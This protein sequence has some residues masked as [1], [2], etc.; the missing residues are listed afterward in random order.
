LINLP[1]RTL[2]EYQNTTRQLHPNARQLAALCGNLVTLTLLGWLQQ[3]NSNPILGSSLDRNWKLQVQCSIMCNPP[4]LLSPYM[5]YIAVKLSTDGDQ[6]FP[7]T[8]LTICNNFQDN[9]TLAQ[10][11]TTFHQHLKTFLFSISFLTSFWIIPDTFLA[12][13]GSRSDFI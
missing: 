3:A 12:L 2:A 10:L 13:N 11:L 6:A 1:L 9:L 7:I 5:C 4:S 8:R